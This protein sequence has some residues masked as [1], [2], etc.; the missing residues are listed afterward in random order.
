MKN[1]M[2]LLMLSAVFALLGAL[3]AL[4]L[5]LHSLGYSSLV[6][7]IAGCD[8]V[9]A[10]PY[11][12][13]LGLP[14]SAYGIVAF[15]ALLALSLYAV[16]Q[17]RPLETIAPKLLLGISSLGM[18]TYAYFTYLEAFVILAWCFWCVGS[19]LCMLGIF[20][21]SVLLNHSP[22]QKRSLS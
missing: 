14:V 7:P 11:S 19:S 5:L 20:V 21:T 16:F 6:C 9:Q 15:L 13:I 4:Y 1:P 18:L 2:L 3:V 17:E 8:K 22:V 10:S 12:K